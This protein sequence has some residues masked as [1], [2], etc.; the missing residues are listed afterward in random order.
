MYKL[1][2]FN[3]C[4]S[5]KKCKRK[6]GVILKS[7]HTVTKKQK[8]LLNDSTTTTTIKQQQQQQQQQ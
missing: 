3:N 8:W 7:K 2:L 4:R 6:F 5:P 1:I